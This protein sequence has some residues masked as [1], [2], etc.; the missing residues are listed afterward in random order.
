MTICFEHAHVVEILGRFP[1]LV[2]HEKLPTIHLF[3]P[4]APP[5]TRSRGWD[6]F[7]LGFLSIINVR[8][9][10]FDGRVN[11]CLGQLTQ[12]TWEGGHAIQKDQVLH[13]H[14][15]YL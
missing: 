12:R 6:L 13:H 3:P 2:P 4:H 8:L 5:N 11:V 10:R 1:A 14:A 15:Q 7:S 9:L